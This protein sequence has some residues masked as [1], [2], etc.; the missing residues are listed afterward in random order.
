MKTPEQAWRIIVRHTRILPADALPLRA[1]LHH[2]LAQNVAADRDIPPADRA[3]MDG[4]AVRAADLRRVPATLTVIG[5]VAAGSGNAPRVKAGQAVR[6]F[7]GANVPPGADTVV[8]QE[9]TEPDAAVPRSTRFLRTPQQGSHIFRQGENARQGQVLLRAGERLVPAFAGVCAAV[10]AATLRVIRRPTVA[11]L[12]TGEEL[13]DVSMPSAPHQLRNSNGPM[14]QAALAAY[15]YPLVKAATVPD[16]PDRIVTAMRSALARNDVL[17]LTGG[18]S[19]GDYDLVPDAVRQ[20]GATVWLH[21]VAIKPGKPLLFATLPG[22]QCIFGLPGNPLSAMNGF[23]EFVLPAL[24]RLGGTAPAQC[25]PVLRARLMGG[26]LKGDSRQ[27]HI[28]ARV[29]WGNTGP[30]ATPV[31][32]V[33]TA[34]MVAGGRADG[35]IIIPPGIERVS[36]GSMVDVRP[37]RHLP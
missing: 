35:A 34:D 13:L 1:S 9:D 28:L 15:H 11:L 31:R 20:L 8:M 25:R 7:T 22:G 33:G 21:K 6:V 24:A 10:G 29:V 32:S 37:W 30:E 4:Y 23:F 5:E 36:A 14:L 3:A 18:V 17:L 2:V 12:C 27:K 19:V 16:R 26:D